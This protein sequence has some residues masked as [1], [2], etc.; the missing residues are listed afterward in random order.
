MSVDNF[1]DKIKANNEPSWLKEFRENSLKS[2]ENMKSENTEL[3]KHQTLFNDF[4]LEEFQDYINSDADFNF[5]LTDDFAFSLQNSNGI[6]I[7][8][9]DSLKEKGIIISQLNSDIKNEQQFKQILISDSKIEDK[10]SHMNNALFNSGLYIYIPKGLQIEIPFRL[11]T[12]VNSNLISKTIFILEQD[13]MLKVIKEDYSI[14]SDKSVLFS[15]SIEVLLKDGAELHVSHV[16]NLGQN[17][18]HLSNKISTGHRNSRMHWN[19]GYFGGK[20]VRSRVYNV[21]LGEGSEAEDMEVLFGNKEQQFD[22]FSTL[23]HTGKNTI[24]RVLSN[25]VLRDKSISI[26]KGMIKISE[27]AKNSSSFLG[28]HA[29][30]L[31]KEAKAKAIPGLE[32]ET[33]EVKATHSAS[34]SQIEEDKIFYLMSRGLSDEESKKMIA[35]GFFEPVIQ[36]ML[37]DEIKNKLY[38]LLELKWQG[39]EDEFLDDLDKL[40]TEEFKEMKRKEDMFAGHYKYR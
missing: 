12:S 39:R 18:V 40:K 21:L 22:V 30:L 37:L 32:I 17:I 24:G 9:P 23:L 10:F 8:L 19:I 34:V 3:F 38:Q 13:S 36:R 29:M 1:L 6:K 4:D 27:G 31:S 33:N 20:K 26:F 25:G 16:Q 5:H 35:L 7:N 14:R 28:E 11:L 15:D 2:Y